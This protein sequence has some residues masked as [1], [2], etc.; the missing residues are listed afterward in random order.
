MRKVEKQF[1]LFTFIVQSF[2]VPNTA[3]TIKYYKTNI[4]W[5]SIGILKL[6]GNEKNISQCVVLLSFCLDV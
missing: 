3:I 4:F 6:L 1:I 2:E 5:K